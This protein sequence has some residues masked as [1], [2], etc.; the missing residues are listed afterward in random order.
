[1]GL[2]IPGL[3]YNVIPASAS[4]PQIQNIQIDGQEAI[5]IPAALTNQAGQIVR[6]P[7]GSPQAY[8][9]V[10]IR[11]GESIRTPDRVDSRNR[12]S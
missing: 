12:N 5:F 6:T 1:M 11:N 9:N 8:Q 7:G 3:T 10:T 4:A 2:S